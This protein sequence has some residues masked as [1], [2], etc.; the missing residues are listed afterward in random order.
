MKNEGPISYHVKVYRE[1]ESCKQIFQNLYGDHFQ[2]F[3]LEK[4]PT[5]AEEIS[6]LF[7]F[8]G[9]LPAKSTYMVSLSHLT[10]E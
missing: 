6:R 4:I 3:K 8:C 7:E 2:L 1:A 9:L 5:R 10:P